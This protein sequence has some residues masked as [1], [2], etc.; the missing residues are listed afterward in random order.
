M[1]RTF[2][3]LVAAGVLVTILAGTASAAQPKHAGTTSFVASACVDPQNEMVF[4]VDWANETIDQTQLLTV[5]WTLQG[6][7][8]PSTSVGDVFSPAFDATSYAETT[9]SVL[10]GPKG[11]IDWNRWRTI[12]ATASGA[13]NDATANATRRPGHWPAC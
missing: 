7:G 3:A 6:G 10:V 8:Q 1:R 11:P 12:V 9:S 13:F 4:R 2:G 5:T